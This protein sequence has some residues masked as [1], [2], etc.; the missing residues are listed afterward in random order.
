[1]RVI[2]NS[3]RLVRVP[4]VTCPTRTTCRLLGSKERIWSPAGDAREGGELVRESLPR[5]WRTVA[6]NVRPDSLPRA[7]YE[8]L[9]D[10]FPIGW[11]AHNPMYSLLAVNISARASATHGLAEPARAECWPFDLGADAVKPVVI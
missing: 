7:R 10:A 6:V 9:Q 11:P 4:P 5:A 2:R 1:M 8:V 3:F